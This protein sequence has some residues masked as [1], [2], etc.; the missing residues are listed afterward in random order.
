MRILFI[1]PHLSTGGLPQY[2]FK[3]IQCLK[4][5]HDI[6]CIEYANHSNSFIV[7]RDKIKNLLHEKYILLDEDK[8]SLIKQISHIKPDVVFLEEIPE[9]FLPINLAEKIY[10]K[11]REYSI[12][13]T[14]HDSSYNID[15]KIFLPDKFFAISRFILDKFSKLQIP[16]ELMEYP[17]EYKNNIDKVSAKKKLEFDCNKKHV[18]NVGLFTSRKNQAEIIEYAKA[19]R[20]SPIQFHFI[21]NQ[22]D[23]FKWYWEPLMKN[24]PENCK[25]W[26]ERSDV[27]NFYEAADLFL[28]TSR[29]TKNDKETSP[30]VIREAIA[31]NLPS[32]IYNLP[33]YMGMYDEF[34][35]VKYLNFDSLQD[36]QNKILEI[37]GLKNN[38]N[39]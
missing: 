18:I 35:N 19:L 25:W 5:L 23:N 8:S 38:E 10:S 11:D 26:G 32:L 34:T 28:F 14:T 24:F 37:L 31:H 13:E 12:I 29:G 7:Q 15:N 27:E 30:L 36:N 22:A 3:K 6:Y 33:V 4:N 21:G 17:I 2:L 20:N 16:C 1:A 9:Y 39:N